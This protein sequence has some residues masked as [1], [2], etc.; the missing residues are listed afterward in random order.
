MTNKDYE[1]Y[2]INQLEEL[3]CHNN[4]SIILKEPV[5]RNTLP[6]ITWGM[7][8]ISERDRDS[9]SV[10]F[11]SYYIMDEKALEDIKKSTKLA[12]ENLVTFGIVP[13]HPHTG[14]GYISCGEK[15]LNGYIVKEFKE[16]PDLRTAE[17]YL[18]R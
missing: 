14:Y 1:Y 18:K 10:I 16:K 6:A 7:K 13:N 15:L 3:G 12:S 8:V 9:I 2:V 17:D 11:S 5:G 4:N